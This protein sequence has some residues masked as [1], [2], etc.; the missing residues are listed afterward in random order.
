MTSRPG[1]AS[2][3]SMTKLLM[4]ELLRPIKSA[5]KQTPLWPL[6][7]PRRIHAYNLGAG[8][9]GTTTVARI[10]GDSYRSAHESRP[11]ET[12]ALLEEYWAGKASE[13]EVRE[14]LRDRDRRHRY[15]FESSPYLGPFAEHLAD[16]FPTAKFVLTVRAPRKWLRSVIDKC[17]N[18]PRDELAEHYVALRDLCYGRPPD[19]YS[20]EEAVL[21][22]HNLHSLD[23]YLQYW[24]WHNQTVLNHVPEDR[25]LV[26]RTRM[27]SNSLP[28]LAA[29]VGV[30]QSALSAPGRKNA[31]S[32]RH[33]VLDDVSEEYIQ[34]LI[35]VHCRETINALQAHW[36]G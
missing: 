20:D 13:Q 28:Q 18:S 36:S 12:I 31:S 15:E 3:F 9:T 2:C 24:A 17:I 16:I 6:L 5:I 33:H 23:G 8:R 22:S 7:R 32:D 1:F 19:Q 21:A 34:E 10:F 29:F 4:T 30:N 14:T 25:L 27:L 11:A 35:D 26:L